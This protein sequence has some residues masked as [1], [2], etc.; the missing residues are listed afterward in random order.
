MQTDPAFFE[1]FSHLDMSSTTEAENLINN[2]D[3]QKKVLESPFASPYLKEA[4]IK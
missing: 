3:F 1:D 2:E 4:F